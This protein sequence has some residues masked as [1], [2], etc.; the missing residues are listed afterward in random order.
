MITQNL[1][2]RFFVYTQ[3]IAQKLLYI[4]EIRKKKEVKQKLPMMRYLLIFAY[5]IL[6]QTF[7]VTPLVLLQTTPLIF[8]LMSPLYSFLPLPAS[9]SWTLSRIFTSFHDVNRDIFSTFN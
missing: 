2:V 7:S 5:S 3:C 4:I 9:Y 6:H 1:S 8:P